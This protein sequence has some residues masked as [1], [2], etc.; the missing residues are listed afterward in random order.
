MEVPLRRILLLLAALALPQGMASAQTVTNDAT[1]GVLQEE[2]LQCW[3]RI[4]T[5]AV[6]VAEPFSL[7]LT[8]AI[9]GDETRLVV[10]DQAKLS[11]D[12][13]PLSPFEVISG[14]D[15]TESESESA[16]Q[17]FFQREYRLRVITDAAFGHDV[18]VPAVVVTYRLQQEGPTGVRTRGIE[19][20]HE[21]PPLPVRILSLVPAEAQDIREVAPENFAQLDEAD[22]G[23]RLL[24]TA[25]IA[26]M[27][28]GALGLL[29]AVITASRERSLKETSVSLL[30]DKLVLDRVAQELD[31]VRR[32]RDGDAWNPEL[33]ARALAA[34]RIGAVYL[35]VRPPTQFVL[36]ARES[37]PPGVLLHEAPRRRIGISAAVTPQTLARARAAITERNALAL[38]ERATMARY[39]RLVEMQ[40]VIESFT[41]AQYGRDQAVSTATLDAALEDARRVVLGLKR[42]RGWMARSLSSTSARFTGL[43]RILW[44]R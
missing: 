34:S 38:E 9:T 7:L 12:A 4:S 41:Q 39:D 35:T 36:G 25:G 44:S 20:R 14:G 19:R 23:A 3:W 15:L 17:R 18:V 6:R 2:P 16:G 5:P 27:V 22:V 43:T 1:E 24:T 10:V 29:L 37:P 8:C 28:L 32:G 31:A 33:T 11:P 26:L 21:L 13:I 42:E 30:P 40:T